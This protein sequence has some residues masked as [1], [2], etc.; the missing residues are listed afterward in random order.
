MYTLN[1]IEYVKFPSGRHRRFGPCS[2]EEFR[3]D[4]LIPAILEYRYV[5]INFDGTYGCGSGFL[6]EVFGGLAHMNISSESIDFLLQNLI[7]TE[8]TTL[9]ASAIIYYHN[10]SAAYENNL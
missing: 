9:G 1:V 2:G 7:C 6:D 10:A 5:I 8:D 3:D 4:I